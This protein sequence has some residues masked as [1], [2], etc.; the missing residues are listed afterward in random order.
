MAYTRWSRDLIIQKLQEIHEQGIP[1]RSGGVNFPL[2]QAA[3]KHFGSWTAALDAAG[4]PR[5]LTIIRSREQLLSELRECLTQH[6]SGNVSR[7]NPSLYR[8][9]KGRFGSLAAAITSL[10]LSPDDFPKLWRCRWTKTLI[11]DHLQKAHAA[12][13]WV[14]RSG[15]GDEKLARAAANH[16]GTWRKA[17]RAAGL[18]PSL[19]RTPARKWDRQ[20]VIDGIRQ[21]H[22][23]GNLKATYREDRPLFH[24]AV[25]YFG[26]W[27]KALNAAGVAD[28]P[29]FKIWT[30]SRIHKELRDWA[31]GKSRRGVRT[32]LPQLGD[33]VT[34]KYGSIDAG[35]ELLG[36]A[37][38][39]RSWTKRRVIEQIQKHYM[40]GGKLQLSGC[41]DIRLTEAAKRRFGSWRGAVVAA[42]LGSKH[43]PGPARISWSKAKVIEAIQRRH[44]AGRSLG[45]VHR[46]DSRLYEAAKLHF[47][48]W[49]A[50]CRAAGLDASRTRWSKELVIQRVRDRIAQGLSISSAA[51]V[52]EDSALAGA[53]WR[54]FGNYVEVR[55]LACEELGDRAD[56]VNQ[57]QPHNTIEGA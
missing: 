49:R 40:S 39:P 52:R 56:R 25:Q 5:Y 33:A 21:R 30:D 53:I 57:T 18:D 17:V 14:Y 48:N 27:Y 8:A 16:F 12:G 4:I 51:I 28:R 55:H 29:G 47:G 41:G 15:L 7:A 45:A 46:E 22:Q 43:Q 19:A 1:L 9:V 24:A 10:G 20:F 26:N 11:I 31:K 2:Y 32:E 42:G 36:V 37:P 44:I 34:R 6:P 35:L 13:Q 54:F 3:R 38:Q 50:A 23:Q